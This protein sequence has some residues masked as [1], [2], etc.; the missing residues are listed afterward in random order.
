MMYNLPPQPSALNAALRDTR[1]A[2]GE[3]PIYAVQRSEPLRDANGAADASTDRTANGA[4]GA[5][6]GAD[7]AGSDKAGSD[8]VGSGKVGSGK[9]VSD[10]ASAEQSQQSEAGSA[11]AGAGITSPASVD[12]QASMKEGIRRR[13]GELKIQAEALLQR[14]SV[15]TPDAAASLAKEV[16][17]LGIE[18]KRLVAQ[19]KALSNAQAGV[20]ARGGASSAANAAL[21]NA[22]VAG[23]SSAGESVQAASRPSSSSATQAPSSSN[24]GASDAGISKTFSS[25][26][27]SLRAIE[28]ELGQLSTSQAAIGT[29]ESVQSLAS[30][31]ADSAQANQGTAL[32]AAN[33]QEALGSDEVESENKEQ[34]EAQAEGQLQDQGMAKLFKDILEKLKQASELVKMLAERSQDPENASEALKTTQETAQTFSELEQLIG[35]LG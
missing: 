24:N 31:Q 21:K 23:D 18:L 32:E 8:K 17:R 25:V 29:Y 11:S 19:Y 20:P 28:A 3:L 1:N 15:S 2:L 14:I 33:N 16:K 12:L 34:S 6:P 27:S 35:S 26:E 4:L 9:A 7:Q 5:R 30:E 13:A 22:R 10:K